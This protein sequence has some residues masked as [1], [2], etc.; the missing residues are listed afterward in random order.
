MKKINK[1]KNL[2]SI[3]VISIAFTFIVPFLIRTE[4]NTNLEVLAVSITA[5]GAV[6]TILTLYIAFELYDR[7]GLESRFIGKKTDKVLELV[8]FLKGKYIFASTDEIVYNLTPDRNKI[9][10][11]KSVP[12]YINDKSKIIIVDYENYKKT[13][14]KPLYEIKRSYW[15]PEKI[16]KKVEFLEFSILGSVEYP[17]DEKYI[18][19]FANSAKDKIKDE[20]I[21][22]QIILPEISFD[23]FNNNLDSLIKTIEKWLE[24]RS[25]IKLDFN[26]GESEKFPEYI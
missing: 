26:L 22:W 15:L 6:A 25:G 23:E 14:G 8:D 17:F 11:I 2:V 7:F 16:K 20:S 12:R 10:G 5:I 4:Q 19:F 18:R 1:K 3:S 21:E 13:W 9:K 24:R